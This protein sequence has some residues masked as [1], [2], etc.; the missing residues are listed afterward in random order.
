M[1]I[2]MMVKIYTFFYH[3]YVTRQTYVHVVSVS[4]WKQQ[5]SRCKVCMHRILS[6]PAVRSSYPYHHNTP[7]VFGFVYIM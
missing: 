4:M 2:S 6:D 3:T 5:K 7:G 1:Q